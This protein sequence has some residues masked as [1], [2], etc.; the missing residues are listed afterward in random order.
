MRG[1]LL[2]FIVALSGIVPAGQ[3]ISL[4]Y[5]VKAAYLYNFLKYIEWPQ[6]ST[7]PILLC[8]A[9]QNPLGTVLEELI[10][11]EHVRGRALRTMV[12]LEPTSE[13]DVVFTPK[14]SNIKAYLSAA[15]GM[16]I[17]TV[18]E[19]PRYLEQG[20]IINFITDGKNVRF[21]INRAAAARVGL[22]ISSRL[23]QLARTA[24]P[25]VEER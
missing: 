23:L 4:E 15:A 12:I 10:R 8:V 14:T 11:N 13:C 9:G 22:R 25:E 24:E 19:S 3:E 17:L 6:P 18:G 7:E 5:R 16:P 20:G 2:P 1:L 21:E